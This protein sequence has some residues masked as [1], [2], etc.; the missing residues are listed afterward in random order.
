MPRRPKAFTIPF[1]EVPPGDIPEG[2]RLLG[3]FATRFLAATPDALAGA[4][5]AD[6]LESKAP[7]LS[8]RAAR[9]WSIVV[10]ARQRSRRR[11]D[12]A[13]GAWM[14]VE[15]AIREALKAER[16]AHGGHPSVELRNAELEAHFADGPRRIPLVGEACAGALQEARARIE[17]HERIIRR[18]DASA[19]NEKGDAFSPAVAAAFLLHLLDIVQAPGAAASILKDAGLA[20]TEGGTRRLSPKSI[21]DARK[22][23]GDKRT[24]LGCAVAMLAMQ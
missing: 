21:A 18:H 3:W 16:E 2:H 12:K 7:G 22:R 11:H 15:Q 14:R 4:T 20:E 5:I 1:R 9:A 23:S 24:R 8:A 19:K 10:G 17:Y 6:A 13:A